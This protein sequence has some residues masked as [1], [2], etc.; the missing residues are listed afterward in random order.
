MVAIKAIKEASIETIKC[1]PD[2][3]EHVLFPKHV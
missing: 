1:L 2:E 3:H